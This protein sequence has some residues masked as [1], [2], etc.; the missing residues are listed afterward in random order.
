MNFDH[1]NSSGVTSNLN[2]PIRKYVP[3]A[4]T[5]VADMREVKATWLGSIAQRRQAAKMY[6][7]VTAFRGCL[8]LSTRLTQEE[9][10]RIPS[11]ATAKTRREAATITAAAAYTETRLCQSWN[12]RAMKAFTSVA[13]ITAITVM[14]TAGP[15]PNAMA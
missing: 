7:T 6:T 3:V 14:K 2:N 12:G 13:P 4:K 15:L 8:F 5:P 1:L 11:R 10:G 9:D